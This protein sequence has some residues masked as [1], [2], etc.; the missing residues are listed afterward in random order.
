MKQMGK[1]VSVRSVMK[2]CFPI[3]LLIPYLSA[4]VFFFINSLWLLPLP[5]VLFV[6]FNPSVPRQIYQTFRRLLDNP[7]M[8]DVKGV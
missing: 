2:E 5:L 3:R 8:L 7:D 4:F 6:I 1:N